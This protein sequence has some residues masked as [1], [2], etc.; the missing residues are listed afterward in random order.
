MKILGAILELSAKQ[1]SQSS[2]ITSKL[3]NWPNWLCCLA[4]SSKI[5][6]RISAKKIKSSESVGKQTT[7]LIV[8]LNYTFEKKILKLHRKGSLASLF[9]I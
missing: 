3:P 8:E 6:R 4:G 9:M 1:H 2:P 7:Q 5:L